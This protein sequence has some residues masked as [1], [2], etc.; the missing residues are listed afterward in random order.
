MN[1]LVQKTI[2]TPLS[3]LWNQLME[4]LPQIFIAL[5][6]LVSAAV[7]GWVVKLAIYHALRF[8]HFDR[9]GQRMGLATVLERVGLYR[10]AS[11]VVGH[12]AGLL[13]LLLGLLLALNSLGPAGSNIV[14]Q[15]FH[16]LPRL[17]IG[18][19]ILFLGGIAASF[20]S[21]GVLIAAANAHLPSARI[22][23]TGVRL[24][25]WL[26][27]AFV[28]L[29]HLGI[30][31]TTL[32]ITFGVVFGGL[33]TALA[34]AFGMAGKDMARGVLESVFQKKEREKAEDQIEHL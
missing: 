27:A 2:V 21:R 20:F 7:L 1:D 17:F 14:L 22:M 33:V 11:H 29:E 3:E 12:L 32:A 23:A 31:R 28:A 19:L 4:Y 18:L 9:L 24:L 5:V 16:Y 34:V 26:L 13:V 30:G 6:L 25:I 8:V 10:G 15:F